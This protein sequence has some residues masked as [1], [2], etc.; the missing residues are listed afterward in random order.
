VLQDSV[1]ASGF[2]RTLPAMPFLMLG[3]ALVFDSNTLVG[4]ASAVEAAR[5]CLEG[6]LLVKANANEARLLTGERDP[7]AATESWGAVA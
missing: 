2:L 1:Q 5:G 3:E 7:A 6:C 4:P